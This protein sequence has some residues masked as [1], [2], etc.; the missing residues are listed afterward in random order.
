MCEVLGEGVAEA[1]VDKLLARPADFDRERP[2][3]WVCKGQCELHRW[4]YNDARDMLEKGL[5]QLPP[6]EV[7]VR[8]RAEALLAQ[9]Y[10]HLGDSTAA[11]AHL[12][13]AMERSPGVVR[14]LDMRLPVS[15]S[16][17]SDQASVEAARMLGH[18]PRFH[19]VG[20]GFTISIAA[21]G[22]GLNGRLLSPQGT[23]LADVTS[24]G[25]TDHTEVAREFCKMFHAKAFASRIDLSQTDITALE[26]SNESED[27]E[28]SKQLKSI[29]M[30]GATDSP[31]P[32]PF[33]P[34]ASP[35]A[36]AMPM[37]Q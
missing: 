26:G 35:E 12:Q 31:T 25:G 33:A 5:A 36:P 21:S 10:D 13:S 32:N 2:Y 14:E 6:A 22:A 7:L 23:V 8:A 15:I 34:T 37:T 30:P 1:E 4:D 28:E 24:P 11:M 18:S 17:D 16:F 27:S 9:A 3:L 20:S 19:N 29:L